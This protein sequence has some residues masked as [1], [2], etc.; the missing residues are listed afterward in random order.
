MKEREQSKNIA[1]KMTRRFGEIDRHAEE[2]E[3][4]AIA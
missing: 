4:L 3:T 1:L 2:Q